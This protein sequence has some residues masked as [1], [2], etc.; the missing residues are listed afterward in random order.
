MRLTLTN[1]QKRWLVDTYRVTNRTFKTASDSGWKQYF[2]DWFSWEI[3]LQTD[4]DR[5][6]LRVKYRPT[7]Q[8]ECIVSLGLD[9]QDKQDL[10]TLR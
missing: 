5:H 1:R 3:D 2:C 6:L 7:D 8:V 10:L 4:S 9:E